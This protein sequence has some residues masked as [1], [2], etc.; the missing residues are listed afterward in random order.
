MT[1]LTTCFGCYQEIQGSDLCDACSMTR[2]GIKPQR[3][4]EPCPEDQAAPV[5]PVRSD[6]AAIA[7]AAGIDRADVSAFSRYRMVRSDIGLMVRE[8]QP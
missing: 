7:L 8:V 1:Q 3:T 5:A 4:T 6:L 2:Y